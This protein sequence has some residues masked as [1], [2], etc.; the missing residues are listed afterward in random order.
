MKS[1]H[2]WIHN[3]YRLSKL[4]NEQRQRRDFQAEEVFKFIEWVY[5]QYGY[6]YSKPDDTEKK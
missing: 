1:E 6:F 3:L 5:K 4:Y 2:E